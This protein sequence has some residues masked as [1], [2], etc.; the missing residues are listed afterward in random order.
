MRHKPEKYPTPVYLL[1][2]LKRF[3]LMFRGVKPAPTV[4]TVATVSI[5]DAALLA[6]IKTLSNPPYRTTNP[7]EYLSAIHRDSLEELKFEA[8]RRGLKF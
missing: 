1:S 7:V 6:R 2:T 5:E 3:E 8:N 4:E